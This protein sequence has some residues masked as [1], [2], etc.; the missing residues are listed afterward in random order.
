MRCSQGKDGCGRRFSLPRHPNQYLRDPR[1]PYCGCTK[2]QDV[3]EDEKK[4][5][6]RRERCNCPGYPFP[7]VKGDLRMCNHHPDFGKEP[8][9]LEME[10]YDVVLSTQRGSFL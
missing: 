7:H 4:N 9:D 6:K 8:T 5:G 2:L 1:C 3:E 10:D